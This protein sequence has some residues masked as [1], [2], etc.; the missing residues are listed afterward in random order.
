MLAKVDKLIIGG[1][2]VFTFLKARGLNVGSSLVEEDQLELAT[3]V[4]DIF[5]WLNMLSFV[6]HTQSIK[7]KNRSLAHCASCCR[8]V[9]I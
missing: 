5:N 2:M 3:K 1:G 4:K 7:L 8:L 6:E 9:L